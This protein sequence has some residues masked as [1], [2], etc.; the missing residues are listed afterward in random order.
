M[1]HSSLR[2]RTD[3]EGGWFEPSDSRPERLF[4]Q[5]WREISRVVLPRPHLSAASDATGPVRGRRRGVP[6][7]PCAR[8]AL[9]P[10]GLGCLPC[11]ASNSPGMGSS[12]RRPGSRGKASSCSRSIMSWAL[13]PQ[14]GRLRH[15]RRALDLTT[16]P[17]TS[18]N[19]VDGPVMVG[20]EFVVR[21]ILC[22]AADEPRRLLLGPLVRRRCAHVASDISDIWK[23]RRRRCARS[24]I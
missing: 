10:R 17:N 8:R 11:S 3:L 1:L 14:R 21:F 15:S 12:S 13:R 20:D 9:A 16:E 19:W 22:E 7:P 18:L 23:S 6:L 24:L 5:P 4:S 2:R